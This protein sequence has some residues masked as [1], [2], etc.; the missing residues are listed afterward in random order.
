MNILLYKEKISTLQ[1]IPIIN[2][3]LIHKFQGFTGNKYIAL[4]FIRINRAGFP[5]ISFF[6]KAI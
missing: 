1:I 3:H 5:I 2:I 6:F 4:I